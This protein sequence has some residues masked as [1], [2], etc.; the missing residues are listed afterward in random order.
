MS[1]QTYKSG[2]LKK[3]N[4]SAALA[5]AP[6]VR[7]TRILIID[8]AEYAA[9]EGYKLFANALHDV[10]PEG[11]EITTVRS[12]QSASRALEQEMF[13]AILLDLR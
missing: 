9:P 1:K 11:L 8:D 12:M 2:D 4:D 7:T 6:P 3:V 13:D 10:L 5:N